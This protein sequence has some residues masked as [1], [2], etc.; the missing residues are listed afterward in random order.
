VEGDGGEQAGKLLF[1]AYSARVGALAWIVEDSN[2]NQALD[3]A[4]KFASKIQIVSGTATALDIQAD[5]GA[6]TLDNGDIIQA[7]L[8]VGADGGQS[9]VRGQCDIDISYRSYAQRA[10]VA[11]FHCE[12]PHHGVAHQWFTQDQG[13]VA[14]LPLPQQQV[15]LVWSAPEPFAATLLNEPADKLT[16]RLA[17]WAQPVLGQLK[18]L[19]PEMVRA[20]PLSLIRPHAIT[21][22]RVALVGDAAHVVHPLAGQGMNLGFADVTA[23][24]RVLNEREPHRDCGDARVLGRYARAR[25]EDVLLM[26]LTTDSL[27]RLF[28]A[29][30]QPLRLAR[31]IG[32]NLVDKLPG[33][34]RRLMA[35]A[36]GNNA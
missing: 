27:E 32:M 36:F 16:H 12:K 23:L 24:L 28:S 22:P 7:S 14:L 33:L 21:A 4:L 10:I 5:Y 3:A 19:Q 30:L 34:K 9:W 29:D 17:T 11:N 31:N 15:S 8:I 35:H 18:P 1:D 26:Q 20:F 13:I 25:K 6:I 2:L